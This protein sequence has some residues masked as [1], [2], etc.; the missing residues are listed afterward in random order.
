[1]GVCCV[2]ACGV[3]ATTHSPH[4]PTSVF[5]RRC[6][7]SWFDEVVESRAA[8]CRQAAPVPLI[9]PTATTPRPLAGR[10]APALRRTS[11]SR[12]RPA[13][14]RPSSLASGRAV[15]DRQTAAP[16]HQNGGPLLAT[17]AIS[18]SGRLRSRQ[19]VVA[20]AAII[21]IIILIAA[22]VVAK[23]RWRIVG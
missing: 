9:S 17:V 15:L 20:A 1:M 12:H 2:G 22:A 21:R 23:R 6:R 19:A 8:R 4:P 7:G 14:L 16:R 3:A 13:L 11:A 10:R 5:G 18:C